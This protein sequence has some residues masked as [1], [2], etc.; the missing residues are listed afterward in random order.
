MAVFDDLY[1]GPRWRYGL[2]SHHAVH[3]LGSPAG[4]WILYSERRS[5]DPRFPFGTVDFPH[6]LPEDLARQLDLVLIATVKGATH[7]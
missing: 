5:E 7:R 2:P 3:Y 1:T 6:E 4:P